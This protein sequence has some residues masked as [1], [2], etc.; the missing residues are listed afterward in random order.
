MNRIDGTKQALTDSTGMQHGIGS[1]PTTPQPDIPLPPE[2]DGPESPDP[3]EPPLPHP[4]DPDH[5]FPSYQDEPP[6]QPID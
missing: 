6:V 3:G 4:I 5:P 1:G 2:P